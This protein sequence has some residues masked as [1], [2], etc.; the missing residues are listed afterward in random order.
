MTDSRVVITVDARRCMGTGSCSFHAPE[1][2][3][4]DDAGK[5]VLLL[6][7]DSDDRIR[8]AA[9]ACPTRAIALAEDW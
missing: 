9:D 2:F 1:T 7:R 3:D 6:G 5:V 8:V 4:T